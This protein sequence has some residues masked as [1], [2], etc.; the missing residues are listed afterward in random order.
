VSQAATLAQE[1][2]VTEPQRRILNTAIVGL[3]QQAAE[4]EMCLFAQTPLL[5]YA[6]CGG[7][8]AAT[9]PLAAA[10]TLLFLGIDILDDLADGDLP[11]HWQGYR[12]SEINLA[13][14][15]LL[16]ALPQ[17]II[18]ELEAPASR[19]AAMQRT[20]AQGLLRM[21][22][23]QQQD[24]ALA[25]SPV[26][27]PQEVEELAA[28]K[29]GAEIAMF[30]AMA[31]QFAGAAP[32]MVNA[33]EEFGRALG[34]GGQLASDCHDLFQAS[35]SKDLANGTRTLPIAL[36]LN[37]LPEA[38]RTGF[39][40]LLEQARGDGAAQ[41]AV[42]TRLRPSGVLRLCAFIVELHCQRALRVLERAAPREPAA[43]ALK[44]LVDG[45]SFFPQKGRGQ[46]GIPRTSLHFHPRA[47][48]R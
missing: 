41:D 13:A 47:A 18:A 34:T 11:D 30:G 42:R 21:S 16:A 40:T 15:T 19:L 7:D 12:P 2:A 5:V 35:H 20:L 46:V 4:D 22:A 6:G 26:V 24:L 48:T 14:A 38:E 32:E 37:R 43:T 1:Y 33:Y 44:G 3:R 27:S 29:S 36:Y 17:L 39:L 10:T 28:A 9:V 23:G 45:I 31:A 25:G 8:P